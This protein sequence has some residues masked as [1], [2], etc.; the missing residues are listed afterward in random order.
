MQTIKK[1]DKDS[2]R[3]LVGNFND[4]ILRYKYL[5]NQIKEKAFF[6][7]EPYLAGNIILWRTPLKG[8]IIPFGKLQKNEKDKTIFQFDVFYKELC[9]KLNQN[10]KLINE[11]NNCFIIPSESDIYVIE[12]D[13]SKNIILTQWGSEFDERKATP[14]NVKSYFEEI[15]ENQKEKIRKQKE[16]KRKQEEKRR[17]EE[18]RKKQAPKPISQPEVLLIPDAAD[19][20]EFAM[21]KWKSTSDLRSTLSEE[22]VELFFEFDKKGKGTLTL[23]EESGNRCFAPLQ[24]RLEKK[25]LHIEQLDVAKCEN[26][27]FYIKNNIKCVSDDNNVAHCV[28]ETSSGDKIVEFTLEH[29]K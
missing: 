1:T 10:T 13:L 24:L 25:V 11:I 7:A 4:Y 5:Y 18:E 23:L 16:E 2:I 29:L 9:K 15:I 27:S 6:F 20:F 26:D 28:T 21:G 8:K 22:S 17:R 19:D 3:L 14:F 12:N